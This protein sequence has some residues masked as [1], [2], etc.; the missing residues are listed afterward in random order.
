MSGSHAR[1]SLPDRSTYICIKL[2][3]PTDF[4]ISSGCI[5]QQIFARANSLCVKKE[6][7]FFAALMR[8]KKKGYPPLYLR[9]STRAWRRGR[10]DADRG[11]GV[12]GSAPSVLGQRRQG[13]ACK[14]RSRPPTRYWPL[15]ALG[16]RSSLLC[17]CLSLSLDN[18]RD[19]DA[20]V[21]PRRSATMNRPTRRT[22]LVHSSP[23][24]GCCGYPVLS[25]TMPFLRLANNWTRARILLK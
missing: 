1:V 7:G 20:L 14:H 22:T 23:P 19:A 12:R 21:L 13:D 8:Q 17:L 9:T 3:S 2:F 24:R 4:F 15:Y 16:T 18:P 6:R 25:S 5:A 10:R 11:P